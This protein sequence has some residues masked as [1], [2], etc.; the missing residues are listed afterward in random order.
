MGFLF[1]KEEKE[2]DTDSATNSVATSTGAAVANSTGAVVNCM[3]NTNPCYPGQIAVNGPTGTKDG[4]PCRWDGPID[5]TKRTNQNLPC[6][7]DQAADI[8]ISRDDKNCKCTEGSDILSV[9]KFRGSGLK[10][11]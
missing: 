8:K 4:K 10:A 1:S 2:Q 3:R 6:C 9:F 5:C 11:A 7:P